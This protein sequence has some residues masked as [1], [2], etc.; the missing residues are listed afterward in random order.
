MKNPLFFCLLFLALL[1]APLKA[2]VIGLEGFEK[3]SVMAGHSF[4]PAG[5]YEYLTGVMIFGIEPNLS[6]NK[7][8][9]DLDLA[10]VDRRGLVISKSKFI[11]LQPKDPDKRNGI[12]L[13]EVSNRGGKALL[14][15]YN[16]A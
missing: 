5:S 15:Y 6:S 14:R 12:A 10:P 7:M 2:R 4:G 9:C 16:G 11:V 3:T 8:V 13:I 1:N